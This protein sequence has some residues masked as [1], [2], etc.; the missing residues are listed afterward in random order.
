MKL[1]PGEVIERISESAEPR[2]QPDPRPTRK[3]DEANGRRDLQFAARTLVFLEGDEAE[4]IFQVIDGAVMLYK[5]LPDGRRQVV[6]L[7]GAG[8]VFG[9]SPSRLRDCSAETLVPTHCI[10][11]DR[12]VVERSPALLRSLSTRL[13]AQLTA[14]HE[15]VMLLGRKSAMERISSFLTRCIP[16]RGQHGCPG[17]RAGGEDHAKV[18]L[19][20]TRQEIADYLG[21][22]IETVSRSLTKLKRR[23]VVSI[24]KLDEIYV[25]DVCRLCR[26]TG[27]HLTRGQ[28]CSSHA[29]KIADQSFC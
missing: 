17:P 21:L 4:S 10:A 24:G 15:H 11:L 7:I 2:L 26:L 23:G 9:F 13:Y 1:E 28:W 5:L 6:E 29:Q 18:R 20:M 27:T 12:H 19:T 25:H 14:L 3:D 16:D 8:D 22:T